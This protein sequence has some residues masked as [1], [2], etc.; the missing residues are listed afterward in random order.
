MNF[1]L[2]LLI[3]SCVGTIIWIV[4]CSIRPLTQRGFSQT[5]HY[6]TSLIP[7]FFL[8]GGSEVVNWLVALLRSVGAESSIS[9]TTGTI[10]GIYSGVLPSIL[11]TGDLS[12][13][14]VLAD[15]VGRFEERKEWIL[16]S[17]VIWA[18]G[19]MIFLAINIRQYQIFKRTILEESQVCSDLQ[20]PVKVIVSAQ[21]TTPMLIGLWRPVIVLPDTPLGEKELSM[22]LS[23]ELVH[24]K[25]GDLLV[26]L[27]VF[28]ANA[29]HWFNPVA[30]ALNKQISVFC[31]LSCDEKV[32]R[33][34][35]AGSRRC[36][37]EMLLSMLEYG[38]MQKNVLCTTSL[39]NPKRNMKRRLINLMNTKKMKKSMFALSLIAAISL[40]GSGGAAA[41]AAGTA[42]PSK[43]SSSQQ[44][45]GGGS[46]VTVQYPDGTLKAFDKDGNVVP[47]KQKES[48]T[49]KKLTNEEII[50]RINKY[51]EKGLNVPQ[52]YIDALPQKNLDAINKTHGLKL[53]KSK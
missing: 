44:A 40:V 15:Y 5:W 34:M 26:K 33:N 19:A 45:A 12:F 11:P 46:N 4:L 16:F 7:I 6:Y 36:Y 32:V 35:D 43:N 23:H 53:K 8:L 1:V 47:A 28:A 21:A 24:F 50:D 41:Y 52:G 13:A 9:Q 14:N 10:A 49:A 20:C 29:L 31:E 22:I 3:A 38:V 37:G 30:Y 18:I 2:S 51:I 17:I 25:R 42:V 27:L 39:C 48:K